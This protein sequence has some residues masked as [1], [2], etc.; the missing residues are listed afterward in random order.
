M[1]SYKKGK[2][3]TWL[4]FKKLIFS[5]FFLQPAFYLIDPYTSILSPS[6]SLSSQTVPDFS[7][8]VQKG[9]KIQ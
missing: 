3:L 1:V 7:M 4:W 8:H 2:G 6:D 5:E 9:E